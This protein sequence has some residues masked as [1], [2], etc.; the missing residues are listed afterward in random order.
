[1]IPTAE[2]PDRADLYQ[3]AGVSGEGIDLFVAPVSDVPCRLINKRS[4]TVS[5]QG[6]DVTTAA[7]M[8]L[9]PGQALPPRTRVAI[10]AD[11]WEV[12]SVQTEKEL[13]RPHHDVVYLTG[14]FAPEVALP[15]APFQDAP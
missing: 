1:M 13:R 11:V 5:G 12:A 6:A 3:H 7:T 15:E 4:V 8:L 2:L 9:R 10:G 14:P